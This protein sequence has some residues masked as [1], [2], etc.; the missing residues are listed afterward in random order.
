MGVSLDSYGL[1]LAVQGLPEGA[2]PTVSAL[3]ER[4]CMPRERVGQIVA[5]A[6][7]NGE[8]TR[9]SSEAEGNDDWVKLTRN[10]REALRRM[11][12]ANRDELERSGSRLAQSLLNIVKQGRRRH[13]GAA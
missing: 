3:S 13:R 2:R 6:V 8:I 1:L 4:M 9:S 7:E 12:L 10:G 5:A 11:S